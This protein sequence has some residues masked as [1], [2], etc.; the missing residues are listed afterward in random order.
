MS[1]S[2]VSPQVA[3]LTGPTATGKSSIAIEFALK[4]KNIEIINADSLLV[5]QQFNIGTAKPSFEERQDIP[6]HLIDLIH[7]DE[8]FTAG[9]FYK[10]VFETIDDIHSRQHR[11]LIVGGTGFYLKTLLF[12]LWKTPKADPALRSHLESKLSEELFRELEQKDPLTAKRIGIKDRY[13]LIRSLEMITQSG[14]TPTELHALQSKTPNPLFSLLVID[15]PNEELFDRIQWRTKTMIQSGLIEEVEAIRE[16]YPSSRAL[17]S[18][19]YSETI[20]FL[21]GRP[22]PG[23]KIQPSLAGLASEISLATRQLVKK[24]R[25]WFKSTPHAKRLVLEQDKQALIEI[26]DHIYAK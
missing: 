26:L 1:L 22:P 25:T 21:E 2:P 20:A 9:E 3:I 5:Y 16:K 18:V 24:Q 19:G 13:R 4:Q 11:A 15:R 17:S 6:H 14:K 8:T 7:P 12:G 10:K 23:R